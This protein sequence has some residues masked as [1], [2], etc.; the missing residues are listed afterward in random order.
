M[1]KNI[2][3]FIVILALL[4]F[5]ISSAYSSD[6]VDDSLDAS[7]DISINQP[8]EQNTVQ[9]VEKSTNDKKIDTKKNLKQD[10]SEVPVYNYSQMITEI[11]KAKTASSPVVISLNPGDYNATSQ[12]TW[13]GSSNKNLT[14]N[15]NG[16]ILDGKNSIKFALVQMNNYLTLN[17]IT[18][19]NY[20]SSG[21]GGTIQCMGQINIAD[22]TFINNTATS[23]AGGVLNVQD[24]TGKLS[25]IDNC[26]FINNKETAGSAGAVNINYA[27][28][29]IN[30]SR[31]INNS[32]AGS[33]V[34]VEQYRI[35][36]H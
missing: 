11:N 18:L 26:T 32:A 19:Q 25:T 24:F 30:N 14:I 1:K 5:S 6:V 21:P 8:V 36:E 13:G 20:R 3:M 34:M 10:A 4:F 29:T 33:R 17:N 27:T 16:L 12:I 31:F 9:S 15:G 28:V 2:F 22:S 35:W 7:E 23:S